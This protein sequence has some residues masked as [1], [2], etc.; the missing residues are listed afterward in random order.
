MS[1]GTSEFTENHQLLK[2]SICGH[3]CALHSEKEIQ[4]SLSVGS[5][6]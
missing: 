1:N 4:A 2:E 3:T 6:V 5:L